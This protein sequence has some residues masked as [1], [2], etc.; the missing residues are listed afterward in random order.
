MDLRQAAH[1]SLGPLRAAR[2][3][4][5]IWCGRVSDDLVVG[6]REGGQARTAVMSVGPRPPFGLPSKVSMQGL[7]RRRALNLGAGIL[8]AALAARSRGFVLPVRAEDPEQHG[9]SAFGDLKYPADFPNFDYVDP[10]APKGGT[11]SHGRP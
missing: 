8:G 10:K 3:D 1:R 2:E 6:Y 5:G 7:S 4:A 11:V 9:M